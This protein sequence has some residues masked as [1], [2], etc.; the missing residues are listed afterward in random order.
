MKKGLLTLFAAVTFFAASAQINQGTIL[1]NAKS[2]LS[3]TSYSPKDGDTSSDFQIALK[4]GYF[5]I[6]NLAVGAQLGYFKDS[7]AD[8]AGTSLGVFGRYY[9]N[10]KFLLGAGVNAN[11]Y[12]D[13]SYTS[14]PLEAGYAAF[15]TDNIAI[16]P[17]VTYEI[18]SGDQEGSQ[19]G[20]AVGFSL[21]L[22]RG[23]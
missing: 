1:V 11:K 12:G 18:Q 16:E 19:F 3:F 9:I 14:I 8:D 2:D 20:I 15:I 21:Y 6:D 22:N 17:T 7:E 23:E 4:G 10:G 13:F 5:V